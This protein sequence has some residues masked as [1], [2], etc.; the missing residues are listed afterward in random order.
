[1]PGLLK[2]RRQ[3]AD[4]SRQETTNR[5]AIIMGFLFPAVCI[6]PP[7]YRFLPPASCLLPT[8]SCFLPPA[9]SPAVPASRSLPSLSRLAFR[10]AYH[11]YRLDHARAR[12]PIACAKL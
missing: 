10:I 12:R 9:L 6:L 1:M 11:F 8:A 3:E 7:A 2:E 4:S 5:H